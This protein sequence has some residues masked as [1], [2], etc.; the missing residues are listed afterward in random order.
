MLFVVCVI[1]KNKLKKC[2][3]N[4]DPEDQTRYQ[5]RKPGTRRKMQSP[6]FSMNSSVVCVCVCVWC[7]LFGPIFCMFYFD[8]S[9]YSM[10]MGVCFE[11]LSNNSN[12]LYL[13]IIKF[14]LYIY[15]LSLYIGSETD[16][17]F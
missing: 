17:D 4:G 2:S 5:S 13:L 11:A 9:C 14:L 10:Y 15:S 12:H 8:S 3:K 1:L 7:I 6:F 16:T